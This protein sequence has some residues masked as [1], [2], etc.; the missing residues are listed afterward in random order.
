VAGMAIPFAQGETI[1]TES[2][3]KYDRAMVD[4]L[5]TSAGFTVREL[6]SDDD[7]RCWVAMLE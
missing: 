5:A 4:H 1:W 3:Y 2:S 6:W 7:E